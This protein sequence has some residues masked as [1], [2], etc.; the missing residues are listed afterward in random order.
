MRDTTRILLIALG[1]LTVSAIP[2]GAQQPELCAPGWRI[3]AGG[4]CAWSGER[5]YV[6][7]QVSLRQQL[8]IDLS[9]DDSPWRGGIIRPDWQTLYGAEYR[10][11]GGNASG[12]SVE[13]FNLPILRISVRPAGEIRIRYDDQ[14]GAWIVESVASLN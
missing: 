3:P 4:G 6:R 9:I 5:G 14:A 7:V 11:F 8:G 1:I 2:T 13:Q 10:D 12:F